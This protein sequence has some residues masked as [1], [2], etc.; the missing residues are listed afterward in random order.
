MNCRY[1]IALV[2]NTCTNT[3][4]SYAKN[5]TDIADKYL[6]SNASLP[7]VTLHQF[8]ANNDE[9]S[10]II[11]K[12]ESS[13]VTKSLELEFENFSCITFGNNIFWASL[14]PN[15][16]NEIISLHVDI[17]NLLKMP[18]KKSFDPHMTLMSTKECRY[19]EKV[20][21]LK[22]IYKPIKDEFTLTIGHSDEIGQYLKVIQ[23][24]EDNCSPKLQKRK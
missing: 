23:L 14:L 15:K 24:F 20:N 5:F 13:N 16:I 12:L 21:S 22:K 11:A 7:H 18:I 4:I 3:V 9:L 1:N 10:N 6:L 2:A 8:D 19:E 17:A